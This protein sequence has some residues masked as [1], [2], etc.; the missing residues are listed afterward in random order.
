M[1]GTE[2]YRHELNVIVWQ[3]GLVVARV[4]AA[5]IAAGAHFILSQAVVWSAPKGFEKAIYFLEVIFFACFA[6]VY[7]QLAYDML[8]VFVPGLRRREQRAGAPGEVN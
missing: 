4:L 6:V 3:V 5:V 1:V 7:I 8:T 2:S